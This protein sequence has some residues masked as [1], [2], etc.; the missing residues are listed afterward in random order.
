[1]FKNKY[2]VVYLMA[3]LSLSLIS[4]GVAK[5]DGRALFIENC[6]ACH[7]SNAQGVPG[8]FPA[9]AKNKLVQGSPDVLVKT[10][11]NGRAGMPSF[12]GDLSDSDLAMILT[13]LRAN[14]GNHASGIKPDFVNKQRKGGQQKS[15]SLQAH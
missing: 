5:A 4:G 2:G 14:H 3:I 13:Y 1:M 15:Q 9:L 11:L 7:Q 12:K 10:V 6:S 8:A